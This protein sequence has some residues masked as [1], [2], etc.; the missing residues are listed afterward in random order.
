MAGQAPHPHTS[1]DSD[2]IHTS[3]PLRFLHPTT[4]LHPVSI[5]SEQQQQSQ[6]T[7]GKPDDN[8]NNNGAP[9]RQDQDGQQHQVFHVW[10]SRDNRKGRRR[11]V[12]VPHPQSSTA[13]PVGQGSQQLRK[14]IRLV[15]RFPV[16]DVNYLVAVAF[17]IGM[18][19]PFSQ[20]CCALLVAVAC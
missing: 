19:A 17:V 16:W 15:T 2:A 9:T 8:E 3:G 6:P 7:T 13:S 11:A 1:P 12:I 18:F 5:N 14:T 10:R 20:S 4:R